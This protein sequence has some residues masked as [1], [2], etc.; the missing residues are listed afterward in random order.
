MKRRSP[1]N[2]ELQPREKRL[3]R[4]CTSS[5]TSLTA[6]I[7]FPSVKVASHPVTREN[8]THH[9]LDLRLQSIELRFGQGAFGAAGMEPASGGR[10]YQVRR[11][12]RD[13]LQ[14]IIWPRDGRE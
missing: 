4:F 6:S 2:G 7:S 8:F 13:S 3:L 12:A 10:S 1:P 11:I 14:T 9:R 5:R